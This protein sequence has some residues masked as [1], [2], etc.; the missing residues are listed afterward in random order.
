MEGITI[1]PTPGGTRQLRTTNG[2]A[3]LRRDEVAVI[4]LL[5]QRGKSEPLKLAGN[6]SVDDKASPEGGKAA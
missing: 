1:P 3:G 5:R 2:P 4:E 6:E